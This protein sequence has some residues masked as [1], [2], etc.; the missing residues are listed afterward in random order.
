MFTPS[1]LAFCVKQSNAHFHWQPGITRRAQNFK[2]GSQS[3]LIKVIA[4]RIIMG[5]NH[6]P[7]IN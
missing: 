7:E 6:K 3:D 4:A 1:A 2:D 5:L